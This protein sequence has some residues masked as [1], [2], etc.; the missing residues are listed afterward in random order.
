MRMR[1]YLGPLAF[2]LFMGMFVCVRSICNSIEPR[3]IV[4]HHAAMPLAADGSEPNVDVIDYVHKQRGFH[5]FY[6]GHTYHVGYHYVVLRDGSIQGGRPE[7]L[8]GAHTKGHNSYL[9]ICLI[10]NFSSADKSASGMNMPTE[11]QMASLGRLV[12]YLQKKYSI[13]MERIFEHRDLDPDTECPGD[14]FPPVEA[15]VNMNVLGD[16]TAQAPLSTAQVE[17]KIPF[18]QA[19][20]HRRPTSGDRP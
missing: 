13:P 10:G 3:G 8:I 2:S 18:T 11:Q 17:L 6:W 19:F 4:I 5:A 7:H 15:L 12:R 16:R 14:R 1:I 20:S 9:G